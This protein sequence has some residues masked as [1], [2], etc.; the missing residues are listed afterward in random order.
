MTIKDIS[1]GIVPLR[2][3]K[4]DF[5]EI[6]LVRHGAGHWS[7]PKG[8]ADP[9]EQP[10]ETAIRELKEETGLD[11]V[12]FLDIPQL[13]EKYRF[14]AK[15]RLIDKTVTYFTAEVEGVICVQQEEIID[16]KWSPLPEAE[17]YATFPATKK[18]CQAVYANLLRV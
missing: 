3:L 16:F 6:L 11:I 9:G 10:K 2:R 15:G 17:K 18:V 1:Y 13:E 12:S 5:W 14:R 8:H 4:K 7:F